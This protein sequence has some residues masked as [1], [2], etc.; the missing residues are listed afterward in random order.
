MFLDTQGVLIQRFRFFQV[1]VTDL[2]NLE[3][4]MYLFELGTLYLIRTASKKMFLIRTHSRKYIEKKTFSVNET[5]LC[6]NIE[7][8]FCFRYINCSLTDRALKSSGSAQSES[9]H[10]I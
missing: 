3:K 7:I 2:F 6:F 4:N 5:F 8:S 1:I 10:L 9:F